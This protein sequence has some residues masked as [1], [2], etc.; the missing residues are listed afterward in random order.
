MKGI[1]I[2]LRIL[3][4]LVVVLV[5]TVFFKVA[6]TINKATG[7]ALYSSVGAWTRI[8]EFARAQGKSN[9]MAEADTTVAALQHDLKTWRKNAPASVDIAALEK[10]RATA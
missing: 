2:A 1:L 6:G 10:M 4:L 9:Y 3:G 8:Q 7:Q 5:V